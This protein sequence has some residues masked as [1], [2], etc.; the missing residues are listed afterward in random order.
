MVRISRTREGLLLQTTTRAELETTCVRCLKTIFFPVNTE[1][2]ELYQF[3]SRYREET[4]LVLSG[5]GYIDLGP[6]CRE[7]L[8]IAMPIKRLCKSDCKGL[9]I[10]CGADLNE[11]TCEHPHDEEQ[12][13]KEEDIG[14][15][16]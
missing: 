11:T 10:I 16:S 8:I 4:D 5:D 7:Y 13:P 12:T 1:F 14:K 15:K 9:C 3:P 6:L 2:Q